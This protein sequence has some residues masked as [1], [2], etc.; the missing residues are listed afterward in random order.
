MH[1]ANQ[2]VDRF[3]ALDRQA[4]RFR[5][6]VRHV[7]AGR[8]ALAGSVA[9]A[10]VAGL[11]LLVARL[12]GIHG[13]TAERLLVIPGLAAL[14]AGVAALCAI[15]RTPP[16]A[17]TLAALDAANA[18]G[19]LVLCSGADGASA[20][21]VP[22]NRLPDVVWQRPRGA[23]VALVL[24]LLFCLP[25]AL[26]P[27]RFFAGASPS[28]TQGLE[29]LV[30]QL[31]DRVAQAESEALLPEPLIAAL[32]NQLARIAE[33]GDAAD[34]ARTLEALDHIEEELSKSA[35][36][37]AEAL[38][39]EQTALQ[40]MLALAE[41]MAARFETAPPSDSQAQATAEALA[42]LLAQASLAPALSSNLLA[43]VAGGTNSLLSATLQQL[44]AQLRE[45]GL[46]SE[47]QLKRLAELK[48]VDASACRGSGSCTNAQACAVAL[49]QLLGGNG[50]EAEAAASLAALCGV[51]GSGSISR[52][53]GDAPLTWIDPS[54][55]EGVAFKDDA[56]KPS[57]LPDADPA[58]LEG[59]S[60]AAPEIADTPALVTPGALVEVGGPP[61][62][63]APQAPILPRHREAVTRFFQ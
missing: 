2:D 37:Q 10:W 39:A 13:S 4:R 31:A 60:A 21:S 32:S 43:T 7:L 12:A 9:G 63:G 62:G 11:V 17:A 57:R 53:R 22:V 24:A 40:A 1:P 5:S 56:L 23:T 51:P 59:I 25:A 20:W 35:A 14:A 28:A 47:A 34:P 48:L 52:G 38:A 49:A 8:G 50:P 3:A 61:S 33:S 18:A 16:A 29:S 15:R 26:L 19:G 42:Q 46:G 27:A 41:Q 6:R 30:G 44:A 58:R 54:S 55:R 45:A 36:E